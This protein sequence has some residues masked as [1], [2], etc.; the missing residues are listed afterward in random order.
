MAQSRAQSG[1]VADEPAGTTI[2]ADARDPVPRSAFGRVMG[3][4]IEALRRQASGDSASQASGQPVRT[5]AAGAPLGIEVGS[6][7]RLDAD[8]TP[9][10][11]QPRQGPDPEMGVLSPPLAVQDLP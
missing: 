9:G 10:H 6:A 4:M 11:R 5:T 8:S 7:F 2:R 3:I 1:T